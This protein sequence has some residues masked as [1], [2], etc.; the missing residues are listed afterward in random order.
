MNLR[1]II[2]IMIGLLAHPLFAQLARMEVSGKP[3]ALGD[4]ISAV[5]DANG[6]FCAAVQVLSDMDGF[7]YDSYNGVV[8]VDDNP[9]KDMVY[10]SPDERVLEIYKTG[11]EPL[12]LILADIGMR[13]QAKAV[14]SI[15]I[16]GQA[17]LTKIPVSI[18]VEPAP[19]EILIDGVAQGKGP[20]FQVARG[21]HQV[22]IVRDGYQT[23]E[24]SIDVDANKTLFRYELLEKEDI[25]VQIS[26]QPPGASVSLDGVFIGK[27]PVSFFYGE[28]N[29]ALKL[30]K[31]GYLPLEEQINISLPSVV[32]AYQLSSE[33][34]QLTINTHPGAT[35]TINGQQVKDPSN[36]LIRPM[37]LRIKVT[38]PNAE[39]LETQLALKAHER[40]TID[41]YPEIPL[42]TVQIAVTPFDA[43]V[44]LA[45][46][47]GA[48]FEAVGNKIFK[49]IPAGDYV[50]SV[51]ADGYAAQDKK[52]TLHKNDKLSEAVTL[53]RGSGRQSPVASTGS[54]P[55]GT[56]PTPRPIL[57]GGGMVSI[58]AGSYRN[59]AGE[60]ISVSA[61]LISPYE[62]T[63]AEFDRF[64][65]ATGKQK[66][67]D[68]SYGRENRPVIKVNW[69]DAI[70]Y[71]IW[72][73][74]QEGLQPAYSADG[75]KVTFLPNSNGY[76]LPTSDEWE[77]AARAAGAGGQTRYSGGDDA[78][79]VGW[80]MSNSMSKTQPVG[81]KKPNAI[82]LYDMSGNVMEWCWDD[83]GETDAAAKYTADPAK[84][85]IIRGGSWPGFE[86]DMEIK[87]INKQG[88][89]DRYSH[90]GFRLVRSR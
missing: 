64:C 18:L 87:K 25:S 79:L 38:M 1:F 22:S 56:L 8:R 16:S 77:Y 45:G 82:G 57:T 9:G 55:I 2:L 27:T 42:G 52:I 31:E 5:R 70:A 43:A 48:T 4:E 39:P 3:A 85:K 41:L 88:P 13:L 74:Q 63:F 6:R 47:N 36:I 33:Q 80:F 28:G 17:K 62:V 65:E 21:K 53:T 11:Y 66:P 23:I 29:Y 19:D 10:L 32:K 60:N 40:R 12:K 61:Y 59:A 84:P 7:K 69:F 20:T 37:L 58:S 24:A 72:R 26:S 44:R 71:C 86:S 73:S 83:Y 81:Q 75:D 30:Q 76:R 54:Q 67:L 14:W 68:M 50:L 15:K 51:T 49:D 90:I 46:S 78:K 34:A 89:Y 35:V